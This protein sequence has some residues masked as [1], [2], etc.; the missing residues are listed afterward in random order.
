MDG[1][2][3]RAHALRRRRVPS[4]APGVLPRLRALI[5]PTS[6]ETPLEGEYAGVPAFLDLPPSHSFWEDSAAVILPVPYEAT[7]SWLA[8]TREGPAAILEASRY[9][10][11]Y[12]EELD[13]E[14]Y[15][16]GICTLP[17]ARLSMAGPE[18]ALAE[19]RDLYSGLLE[20]AGD[21]LVVALGGEHSISSAPAAAW[22]DR[23]G[24]DLSILQ[25]DAHSDLR[26]RYHGT[27]WNHACVMRRVLERTSKIVAVGIRALTAEERIVIRDRGI[28]TVFAHEMRREGWVER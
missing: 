11:W 2:A 17:P 16:A 5:Q 20:R 12:D 25:L 1:G 9:V 23:L 10:E 4:R 24:D 18:R 28:T 13:R 6:P 15:E 26:D 21:R 27:P 19:L 3:C 14:P 22:A 8:G 7:T